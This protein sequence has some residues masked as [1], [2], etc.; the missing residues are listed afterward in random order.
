MIDEPS[1][2]V[3]D[4]LPALR[5]TTT[6]HCVRGAA[7]HSNWPFEN[8]VAA[9]EVDDAV[10]VVVVVVIV[11]AAAAAV[12]VWLLFLVVWLREGTFCLA[13]SC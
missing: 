8:D 7:V 10:V 6:T 3:G 1:D 9:D 13:K 12:V 11:V 2:Y 4:F 5:W